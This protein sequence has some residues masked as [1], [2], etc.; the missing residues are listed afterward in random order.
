MTCPPFEDAPPLRSLGLAASGVAT[1]VTLN[2]TW[3]VCA[4]LPAPRAA[5]HVERH[6]IVRRRARAMIRVAG[7][8]R[9]WITLDDQWHDDEILVRQAAVRW[10]QAGLRE[11]HLVQVPLIASAPLLG[12]DESVDV[13]F[14]VELYTIDVD[15]M[16]FTGRSN[17][18]VGW[19]DMTLVSQSTSHTFL[20]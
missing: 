12:R 15:D 2:F 17:R 7:A 19:R 13:E 1:T 9:D 8:G 6:W 14:S 11:S 4:P 20:N 16:Q 10:A 5:M 3:T 18:T